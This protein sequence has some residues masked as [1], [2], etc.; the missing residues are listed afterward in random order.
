[1]IKNIK[2]NKKIDYVINNAAFTGLR[3]NQ[4]DWIGNIDEQKIEI[5]KKAIEINLTSAFHIS[6]ELKKTSKKSSDSVII[7]LGSIYSEIG[8]DLNLYKSSKIGNPS[9]YFASKGGLLQLTR[10]LASNL[11]PIRVNMVFPGGIYNKQPKS[12]VKK[13]I[14]KTLLK[15]MCKTEDVSNL[16]IFLCDVR[17]SY[18]T[19]QNIF[20][21]GGISCI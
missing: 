11:A 1:M 19:G 9:A 6:K 18:I 10:W 17:A 13:Y 4:K 3:R 2:K 8:P 7:N 12:F 15:R 20:V 5:W 14:N 16:I 21:D